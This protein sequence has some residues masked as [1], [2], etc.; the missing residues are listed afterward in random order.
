LC[1]LALAEI[2][3]AKKAAA[4]KAV[5]EAIRARVVELGGMCLRIC[6]LSNRSGNKVQYAGLE[7]T[8]S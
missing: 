7:I 5:E 2:Y 3:P 8:I 1:E 6:T 4:F